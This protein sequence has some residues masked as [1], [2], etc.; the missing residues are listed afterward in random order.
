M[1]NKLLISLSDRNL[2]L[3]SDFV[4]NNEPEIFQILKQNK[5]IST[6]FAK[7][8]NIFDKIKQSL[9]FWIEFSRKEWA[10]DKQN[11]RLVAK[12]GNFRNC[13]LCN[14]PN[15]FQYKIENKSNGNTLLIGGDCVNYF[16]ELRTMKKLISNEDEYKRYQKLLSYDLYFYDVLVTNTDI[17][18]STEIILPSYYKDSFKK[19]QKRLTQKLRKY[20]KRGEKFNKEDMDHLVL[21]YKN[22]IQQMNDFIKRNKNNDEYLSRD[23]AGRIKRSQKNDFDDILFEV[24]ENGGKISKSTSVKIKVEPYLEIIAKKMKYRL[25]NGYNLAGTKFGAFELSIINENVNYEFEVDSRMLMTEFFKDKIKIISKFFLNNLEVLIIN[26]V[27]TRD[28]LVQKGQNK[29]LEEIDGEI[30]EPS[31]KKIILVYDN[32][33]NSK[34]YRET[35]SKIESIVNRFFIIKSYHENVLYVSPIN[36]LIMIGKKALFSDDLIDLSELN[37]RKITIEDFQR[38]VASQIV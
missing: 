38:F 33:L 37:F 15:K 26:E 19:V 24:G 25:P 16:K 28:K 21:V 35:Y 7:Q 22:E 14:T 20:I 5:T 3:F 17:I 34:E 6:N 11:P 8:L 18:N 2:L 29:V 30:Y 10:S 13:Q 4:K 1:S 36:D 27:S 12:D 9:P 32:D 23:I 31:I